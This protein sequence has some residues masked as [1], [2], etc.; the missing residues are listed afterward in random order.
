MKTEWLGLWENEEK[1]DIYNSKSFKISDISIYT[2][3]VM[4]RNRYYKKGSNR[5]KFVFCFADGEGQESIIHPE[6]QFDDD[7]PYEEDGVYYTED[8]ERLFTRD[9][10]LAIIYGTYND[11]LY[12]L[13][14]SDILPEDFVR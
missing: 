2:R 6:W 12:G 3:I 5:P 4:I 11:T 7:G 10:A 9:E 14:Y 8:G 13:Y 1:K